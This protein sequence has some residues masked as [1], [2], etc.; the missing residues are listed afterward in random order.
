MLNVTNH[1]QSSVWAPWVMLLWIRYVATGRTPLLLALTLVVAVQLLGGSPESLLM[2]LTLVAFWT[3]YHC[4]SR[5]RDCAQSL[6]R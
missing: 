1:L 4:A 6:L 2:T 5:W 3:L